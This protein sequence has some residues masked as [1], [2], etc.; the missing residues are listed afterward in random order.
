ML[1]SCKTPLSQGALTTLLQVYEVF[2]KTG[3]IK[4][5][6]M[7]LDKLK[8]TPCGF[9]FVEYYKRQDALDAVKYLNGTQLDERP[10]R[11]DIDYGFKDGRQFGRGRSGGQVW[12]IVMVAVAASVHHCRN[13]ATLGVKGLHTCLAKLIL[14]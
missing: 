8:K 12:C 4:R 9:A 13:V 2:S 1:L 7:G 10:V 3:D 6:V 14:R 11:V 5:I